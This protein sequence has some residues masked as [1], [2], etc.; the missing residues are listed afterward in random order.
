MVKITA[1]KTIGEIIDES[2]EGNE[3]ETG[4]GGK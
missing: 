2:V 3:V 4:V 1:Q